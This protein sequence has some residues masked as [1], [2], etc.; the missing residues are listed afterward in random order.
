MFFLTERKNYQHTLRKVEEYRQCVQSLT[1]K[2]C[3]THYVDDS[4]YRQCVADIITCPSLCPYMYMSRLCFTV[5]VRQQAHVNVCPA[6]LVCTLHTVSSHSIELD[7]SRAY[8]R[9]RSSTAN[10]ELRLCFHYLHHRVSLSSLTAIDDLP[11]L[12]HLLG[13]PVP[14]IMCA[15][16]PSLDLFSLYLYLSPTLCCLG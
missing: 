1:V 11:M 9:G 7:A 14:L 10:N 3:Q 15:G 16:V 2:I 4:H 5:V 8:S 12:C 6:P 13:L